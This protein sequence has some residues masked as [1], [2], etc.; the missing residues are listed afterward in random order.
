[1]YEFLSHSPHPIQYQEIIT[2]SENHQYIQPE[3]W[4]KNAGNQTPGG[5]NTIL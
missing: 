4:N 2:A 5:Q 3:R 1:M